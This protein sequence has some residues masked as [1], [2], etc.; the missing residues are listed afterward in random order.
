[1]YYIIYKAKYL[2]PGIKKGFSQIEKRPQCMLNG[3]LCFRTLNGNTDFLTCIL[4]RIKVKVNIE[5]FFL[6]L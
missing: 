3:N 6:L 4:H 1:M 5:G 2:R